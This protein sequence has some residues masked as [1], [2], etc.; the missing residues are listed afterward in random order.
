MKGTREDIRIYEPYMIR[1]IQLAERARGKTSPNPIVGAV[2][3]RNGMVVGEGYHEQAGGPHAEL[4]A[5]RQAGELARGA[6]LVVTLEPCNHYGR[7]PPCTEVISHS[8]V[9]KVVIGIIDPNPLNVV[10]GIS[11]LKDAGIEVDIGL[12][13][14]RI[15]KQN[16]VFLKHITTGRPFVLVKVAMSLD[17]RIAE[18]EGVR[19]KFT[20]WESAEEIHRL[21]SEYDAI[22][23]GV[24][25]VK[26]DDPLLTARPSAELFKNPVRV[27]VDAGAEISPESKIVQTANEVRTLITVTEGADA[28]RV[29][30][31]RRTGAEVLEVAGDRD[32]VDLGNVLD[33]LAGL[34]ITSVMVEGG[35]RIISSFVRERLVDK[36]IFFTCPRLVGGQGLGLIDESLTSM[37]ELDITAVRRL[38]EDLEIEAYPQQLS[39]ETG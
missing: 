39:E 4:V 14:E 19:T 13:A 29:K 21:R 17:G 23:V 31:L 22:L 38:G 30:A 12:L 6:T 27:I 25:T 8:G 24:G 1:A 36:F 7:T 16:E 3:V 35:R 28:Q 34:G 37:A 11:R 5:L 20:C 9:S 18:R 15:A 33:Q 10:S 2:V 26:V 32:L